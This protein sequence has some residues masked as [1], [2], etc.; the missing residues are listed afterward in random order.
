MTRTLILL[1]LSFST[2]YHCFA[3]DHYFT[4]FY[5]APLLLEPSQTGNFEGNYRIN[6]AYRNQWAKNLENPMSTFAGSVDLNYNLSKYSRKKS[7]HV[8]VG[9]LFATDKA[10]VLKYGNTEMGLSMA[11]H[12]LL[13]EKE[14]LSGGLIFSLNQRNVNFSNAT[15]EDMFDG[16]S[17]YTAGTSEVLPIN[18][19][20]YFF[21]INFGYFNIF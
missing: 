2:S 1:F 11:Y 20:S 5:G 10:G 9:L 3:Q 15:F 16:E 18:N 12:K 6:L 4:Q 8:S 19:F 14:Y 7:D 17:G 21:C 13:G